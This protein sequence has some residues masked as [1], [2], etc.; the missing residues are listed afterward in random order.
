MGMST[1]GEFENGN[2][3]SSESAKNIASIPWVEHKDFPGVFLKNVVTGSETGELYS[4]HLVRIEPDMKIGLHSHQAHVEL[5]EVMGGSGVCLNESRE[6]PYRPGTMI[7]LACNS[8]HEV[9]AGNDGLYLF[10]KFIS[11]S[12]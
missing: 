1:F 6:I 3:V 7:V 12:A 9:R 4:C 11:V 8:P 10:A 2:L 5:H